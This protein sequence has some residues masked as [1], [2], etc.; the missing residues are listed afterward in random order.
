MV[1]QY[2]NTKKKEIYN[3]AIDYIK[4]RSKELEKA[5]RIG[6]QTCRKLIDFLEGGK[7]IRGGMVYLAADIFGGADSEEAVRCAAAMELFQSAFLIHD[8]IMDRDD[9]RRGKTSVFM[10]YKNQED[11]KTGSEKA[12]HYGESMGICVGDLAFFQAYELLSGLSQEKLP[13]ILSMC[14]QEMQYVGIAQMLDVEYSMPNRTVGEK[15]IEALYTYKTGRYTFSLPLMMGAALAN[16]GQNQI[17]I[18]GKIGVSLGIV[19]QLKDDEIGVFGTQGTTGKIPASD[20][21]EQKKTMYYVYLTENADSSECRKIR[22]IYDKPKP[23]DKDTNYILSL[24]HT[25]DVHTQIE[26]LIEGHTKNA[27]R[28]IEQLAP[29]NS[30]AAKVFHD[31]VSYNV[32]RD[33]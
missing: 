29:V 3:F 22:E 27:Y 18:L 23:T 21:K 19:F 20:I 12:L 31:F 8:D 9:F 26:K 2:F 17:E 1:Q 15:D 25:L 24:I 11:E 13:T 30:E 10:Q 5:S 28:H 33:R 32:V 14:S 16:A 7:M 4:K 6:P